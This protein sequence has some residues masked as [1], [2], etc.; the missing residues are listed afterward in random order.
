MNNYQTQILTDMATQL[1]KVWATTHC[2][3]K[4]E[5]IV[6]AYTKKQ[7]VELAG[8]G[9]SDKSFSEYWSETGNARQLE[10]GKMGVGLYHLYNDNTFEKIK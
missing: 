2:S 10:I 3:G 5:V 9:W 7:A 4:H 6:S 8:A 1:L